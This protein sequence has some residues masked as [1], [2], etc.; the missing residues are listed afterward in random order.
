M[1][2]GSPD[3]DPPLAGSQTWSC[4]R[5]FTRTGAAT[6]LVDIHKLMRSSRSGLPAAW[7]LGM[8]IIFG[9]TLEGVRRV[10]DEDTLATPSSELLDGAAGQM[11]PARRRVAAIPAHPGPSR[12]FLWS[13]S[14]SRLRLE[15][16]AESGARR[17]RA[18]ETPQLDDDFAAIAV[19]PDPKLWM[20]SLWEG[21]VG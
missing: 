18:V 1:W 19:S 2:P 8:G 12:I 17:Y 9:V 20:R 21:V 5:S 4:S 15:L 3:M 10:S 13:R 6:R 16:L 7:P 11:M 14:G